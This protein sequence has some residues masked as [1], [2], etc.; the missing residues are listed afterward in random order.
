[1]DSVGR[2]KLRRQVTRHVRSG[3]SSRSSSGCRPRRVGLITATHAGRGVCLGLAGPVENAGGAHV[4][5][6]CDDELYSLR[7][8]GLVEGSRSSWPARRAAGSGLLALEA[9]PPG[10]EPG[11]G[12]VAHV[13]TGICC[14]QSCPI[15]D[16]V[17][18]L[19][20]GGAVCL[21]C[22]RCGCGAS[23][24]ASPD[25]VPGVPA[26]TPR[27]FDCASCASAV[28]CTLVGLWRALA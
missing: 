18:L 4:C 28:C 10:R 9:E 14:W 11:G 17:N 26:L 16:G 5:G 22:V 20:G 6:G 1:M 24:W 21:W 13:D 23:A 15:S 7:S 12:G 8:S 19:V 2:Y 27:R 25:Y 3:H